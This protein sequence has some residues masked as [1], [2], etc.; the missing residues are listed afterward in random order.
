MMTGIKG[1]SHGQ[2]R[3]RICLG[4]L[5]IGGGVWSMHFIAMLAVKLP[6][7]LS[8]DVTQIAIS[9]LIAVFGT[10]LALAIVSSQK[11]GNAS[12]P[13]SALF[14]GAW[15]RR[16]AL[17]RHVC[18]PGELHHPVFMAGS[19]HFHSH[20]DPGV[21]CRLMVHIP[22]TGSLRHIPW[23]RCPRIGD[24]GNPEYEKPLP[25]LSGHVAVGEFQAISRRVGLVLSRESLR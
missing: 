16:H 8:Y 15:H 3:L 18:D 6:I 17:S 23:I 2:A 22:S 19:R 21:R 9:A 14:F 1:V 20:R 7:P 11:F 4:G 12:L 13:L 25:A 10:A 5:G 24:A